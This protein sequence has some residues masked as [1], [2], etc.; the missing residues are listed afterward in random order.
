MA[1]ALFAAPVG[2]DARRVRAWEAT[3]RAGRTDRIRLV[4]RSAP[5]VGRDEVLVQVS[6]CGVCRTDLHVTDGDL[7]VHRRAVI[8]GHEA[9]GTVLETGPEVSRFVRGDRVGI[10]W[11]RRT[12]GECRWCRRGSENL[13]PGATF[14]GW[15]VDGGYAELATVPAAYAYRI[16]ADL[17]SDQAAPLLCAGI[18]GYRS[19]VRSALPPG[20]R[21]GI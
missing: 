14:T 15:D 4:E 11:L 1:L 13:C 19:L 20:G 6:V 7:P 3:G 17:P 8:P 5:A 10:A 16:P 21:L 18:I 9:V 12:C 2:E